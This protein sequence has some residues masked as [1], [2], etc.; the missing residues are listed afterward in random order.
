[1]IKRLQHERNNLLDEIDK[2]RF[3]LQKYITTGKN[4]STSKL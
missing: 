3:K 1:M 2:C 4:S